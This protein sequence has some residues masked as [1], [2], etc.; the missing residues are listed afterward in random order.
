MTAWIEE[1]KRMTHRRLMCLGSLVVVLAW[2][3]VMAVRHADAQPKR[4]SAA[5]ESLSSLPLTAV[6]DQFGR[7]IDVTALR[8]RPVVLLVADKDG[9]DGQRLWLTALRAGAPSNVA[10]VAAADLVGAPR[11]L[12]GLIKSGFPKDTSTRILMDWDGAVA[13]RV[14]GERDHLVGVVFAADGA[15][16]ERVVLPLSGV[17]AEVRARL[18]NAGADR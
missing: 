4:E 12:R 2:F 6:V 8:G 11:L 13:R 15:F 1:W 16:R 10:V 17:S 5:V 14:R 9:S 3:G 18:L 7:R